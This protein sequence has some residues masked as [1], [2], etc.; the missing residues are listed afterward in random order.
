MKFIGVG[1]V[2]VIKFAS[3]DFTQ[4]YVY[5]TIFTPYLFSSIK[6]KVENANI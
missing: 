6:R 2:F 1:Y 3:D 4:R 5:G